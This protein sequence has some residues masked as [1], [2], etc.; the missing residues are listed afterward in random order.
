MRIAVFDYRVTST[1]PVGGCHLRLLEGLCQKHDFTVFAVEFENPS[2]SRIR[3]VRIP[4]PVRPYI[5]LYVL[6]HLFAP[7]VYGYRRVVRGERFDLVQIV[8][9]NLL[10]GDV[11]TR[12]SAI[13]SIWPGTGG[14]LETTDCG[15]WRTDGPS[16]RGVDGALGLPQGPSRGG[17]FARLIEGTGCN[18]SG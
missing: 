12:T 15:G 8:E 13:V 5:L 18:V 11:S 6:Y 4:L 10:F 16:R 9:S 7:L 3:W 14:R 2:P 17:A 1:N